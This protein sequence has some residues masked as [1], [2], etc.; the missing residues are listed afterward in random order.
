MFYSKKDYKFVKFEKS[1]RK[2]KKYNAILKNKNTGKIVK[3]S[4]GGIKKNSIPYEQFKDTTGLGFY[5]DYDHN[6]KLRRQRY[7]NRHKKEESTFKAYYSAGFFS[8][9]YLW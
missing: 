3:I 5:S 2:D 8:N 9:K 4:F 6:D 7:I 1:K